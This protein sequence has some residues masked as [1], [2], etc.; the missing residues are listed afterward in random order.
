MEVDELLTKG[1]VKP[2]SGGAGFYSGVFVIPK[3]AGGLW[4]QLNLKQYKFYVGIP[5]FK[6]PTIRHV[7]QLIQ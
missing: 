5:S 2:S 3:H 7:W 4:P 6:M 1:A